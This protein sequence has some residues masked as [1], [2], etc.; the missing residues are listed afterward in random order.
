MQRLL[1]YQGASAKLL[2][3]RCPVPPVAPT[4]QPATIGN[5]RLGLA[6]QNH[7][8]QEQHCSCTCPEGLKRALAA[9]MPLQRFLSSNMAAY[10]E[11]LQILEGPKEQGA[12]PLFETSLTRFQAS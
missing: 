9:R 8:I 11:N 2:C 4:L 1:D 12:M 6:G 7:L 3:P 10:A 5:G